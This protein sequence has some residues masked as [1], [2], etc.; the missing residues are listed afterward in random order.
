MFSFNEADSNGTGSKRALHIN[1]FSIKR[2]LLINSFTE[3]LGE[4]F[5]NNQIIRDG[6]ETDRWMIGQTWSQLKKSSHAVWLGWIT[7][8]REE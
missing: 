6:L 3:I 1:S 4:K 7:R 5:W 2:F 8:S